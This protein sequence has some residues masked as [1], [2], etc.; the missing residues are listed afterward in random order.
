MNVFYKLIFFIFYRFYKRKI[1]KM[2]LL[3]IFLKLYSKKMI[4]SSF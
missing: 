2:L 3:N 4:K 1:N